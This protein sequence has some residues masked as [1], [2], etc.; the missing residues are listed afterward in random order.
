MDAIS[1]LVASSVDGLESDRV[2][3]LD[4]AGHLLTA[5]VEPGSAAGLSKRQLQMRR[6]VEA[7]LEHKAEDLVGQTVGTGNARVRVAADLNFDKI[8]RTTQ[9]LNPD[10]QVTTKEERSDIMPSPGQVGAASSASSAS[11]ETTK[12]IETFSGAAGT[13][14]R[15]TVAVM[16]NE[17]TAAD[18]KTPQPWTPDELSR[19]DQLVSNAIGLDKTRGDAITVMSAPFS[20]S[21]PTQE[22]VSKPSVL[23]MVPRYRNEIFMSI[24]LALAF[25]VA[26]QLMKA[27]RA[28]AAVPSP[29]A[30][31]ALP[32]AAGGR[33]EALQFP[34]APVIAPSPFAAMLQRSADSPET[35]ARMLRAWMKES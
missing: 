7:Y 11:Y 15:L 19:V 17:R 4:D 3:V 5:A 12:S 23:M 27:L 2:T 33:A 35:A 9:K 28:A 24:G 34:E 31:G 8:D 22:P 1:S 6:D 32:A 25:V 29:A 16:L 21:V 13:V 14:H 30:R 26:L 18:G 20:V 10:E